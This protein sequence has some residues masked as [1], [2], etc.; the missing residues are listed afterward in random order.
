[1]YGTISRMKVKAGHEAA[2]AALADQW[3]ADRVHNGLVAEFTYQMDDD[4]HT[5]MMA[6]VFRDEASYKANA[7]SPEQHQRYLALIQHLDGEPEW[8]DGQIIFA[9]QQEALPS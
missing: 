8:M 6:V 7:A 4:P 1:M 3:A 9:H 5:M 2:L